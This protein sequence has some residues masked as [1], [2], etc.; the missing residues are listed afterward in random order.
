M[1]CEAIVSLIRWCDPHLE[2]VGDFGQ[3][4]LRE[5]LGNL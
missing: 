4:R 3:A 2:P 5:I 1:E